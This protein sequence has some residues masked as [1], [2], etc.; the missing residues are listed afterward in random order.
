[1]TTTEFANEFDILY[2]NMSNGSPGLTD[3]EKS[4]FLTQAQESLVIGFYNGKL[5]GESFEVTEEVRTYISNLVK[6]KTI[7]TKVAG[8]SIVAGSVFYALPE[9]CWFITYESALLVD[10][11]LGCQNNKNVIVKP[12]TQDEFYRISRNPF[13]GPNYRRVLRLSSGNNVELISA[14]NIS[15]YTLRYLTRPTPIIL[16]TLTNGLTINGVTAITECQL[17]EAIH[18]VILQKAVEL[19]KLAWAELGKMNN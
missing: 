16:T 19:A 12:V 18:R 7:T 6:Q 11:T 4:V 3:Y 10:T 15:S 1:M 2:N 9:D 14:Y 13:L 5:T 17:D 8:D